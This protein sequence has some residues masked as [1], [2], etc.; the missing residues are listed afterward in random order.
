MVGRLKVLLVWS[1]ALAVSAVGCGGDDASVAA[2]PNADTGVGSAAL[3]VIARD[4]SLAPTTFQAAAGPVH[5]T[6]RNEGAI[7]HTL[8]IE[9]VD[10]F[11]LDVVAKGAVDDGSLD[12]A[13]GTYT[14]YCDM[15][16]HR[17]AGMQATLTVG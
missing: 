8:V 3:T 15:P 5:I 11:K 17:Q 2:P 13:P 9:G 14:M 12:L 4:I 7:E 16:G 10:G 6:Y 1:A